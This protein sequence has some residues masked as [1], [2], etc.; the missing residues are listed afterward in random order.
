MRELI[1]AYE[2]WAQVSLKEENCATFVA[3]A[4]PFLIYEIPGLKTI[5]ADLRQGTAF[6]EHKSP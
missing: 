4:W 1:N 3:P 6:V 2:R 5:S